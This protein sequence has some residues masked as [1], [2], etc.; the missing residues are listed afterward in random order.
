MVRPVTDTKFVK[1][2]S[3]DVL[4]RVQ[5]Y[6]AASQIIALDQNALMEPY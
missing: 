4:Q 6:M 2:Q 3:A 5:V 1:E